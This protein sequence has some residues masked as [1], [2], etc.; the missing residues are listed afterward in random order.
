MRIKPV[1]NISLLTEIRNA[2]KISYNDLWN[3]FGRGNP[4]ML[5]IE[6]NTL[7]SMGCIK[8]EEH[9]IEFIHNP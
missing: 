7:E 5:D 6:L 4:T 1:Y 2:K 3:A 8:I 9:I